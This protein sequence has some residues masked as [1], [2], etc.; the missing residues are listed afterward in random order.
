MT[1]ATTAKTYDRQTAK[2]LARV[3]EN[4]PE[5]PSDIMQGWIDN[6]KAMQKALRSAFCPPETSSV[7]RE[8]PTW[9][10]VKMGTYKDANDFTIAFKKYGFR[11]SD[12]AGDILKKI[13]LADTETE[14]ELVLVTVADL[15]F[16]KATRR[17]AIYNRA[18]ELGL[19]LVPAE[20]GPQLRLAY[21]DQP[22][23]EWLL[24]AMEPIADSDGDL[25][26]F[27]VERYGDGQWLF[28]NYGDPDYGWRPD[29]RYRLRNDDMTTLALWY[30]RDPAGAQVTDLSPSHLE[31]R[32]LQD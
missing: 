17:D 32:S 27:D 9:K 22:M 4:M 26:V 3:G 12:W 7:P 31:V 5:L 14:I 2:F 23:G 11:I 21:T 28:A 13:T 16:T 25:D 10:T 1:V 20:V 8:F 29:G 24:M 6:P 18:K 15:G 30:G 19:D